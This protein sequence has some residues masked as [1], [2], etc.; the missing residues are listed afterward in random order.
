MVLSDP[1]SKTIQL[2]FNTFHWVHAYWISRCIYVVAKLGIADLLKDGSQDCD[3]LAAA[4]NTHSDSLYRVLRALAS[5]GIFAETQPRYFELNPLSD[6]LQSNVPGS[7]RNLAIMRGEEHYYKAWENLMYTVQTGKCAIEHLYGMDLFQ[8]FE[9]N[10]VARKLF[11]PVDSLPK[12]SSSS[13][14]IQYPSFLEP[15]DFSSIS[16]LVDIGGGRGWY[17]A[18]IL[19]ANPNITGVLFELPKVI[20]EAKNSPEI[21]SVS[22]RCQLIE[23]NFFEAIPEGGDAYLLKEIV[24]NW[25][26]ERAIAILKR[27]HQAMKEQGRLIV[28]EPVISTEKEFSMNDFLT[29]FSDVHLMVVCSGGRERTETEFRDLFTSAGF[30][31]TKVIPT[32]SEFFTIFEGVKT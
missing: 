4:T 29:R 10:S 7:L 5:M 32:N 17:L 15:Y 12:T 28:I 23:G 11:H 21:A 27:C 8:Y 31:L 9:Q 19:E 22:D 1:K 16:K 20:D 24:H 26:D 18:A 25:D 6:C 30:K 13:K 3:A 2:P 14:E